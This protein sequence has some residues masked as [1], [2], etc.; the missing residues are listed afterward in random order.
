MYSKCGSLIDARRMFDKLPRKDVGLWTNMIAG[1]AQAGHGDEAL[2][3]FEAMEKAGMHPNKMAFL[4]VLK[5]C[6]WAEFLPKVKW[7]HDKIQLAG[8]ASDEKVSTAL[9]SSY[10]KCRS[11]VDARKVFD[12]LPRKNVYSWTALIAGYVLN[13]KAEEALELYEQMQ[14]EGVQPNDATKNT[15]VDACSRLGAV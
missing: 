2:E 12:S 8:F 15:I 7:L 3:R 1:Y 14:R 5:A 4:A 6:T 11:L 13:G 9:I 10:C